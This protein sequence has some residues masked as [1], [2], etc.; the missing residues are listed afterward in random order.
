MALA[1]LNISCETIW[2][3][4]TTIPYAPWPNSFVIR[5]LLSIQKSWFITLN[6]VC[7]WCDIL[8]IKSLIQLPNVVSQSSNLLFFLDWRF[9]M[10]WGA[11]VWHDRQEEQ[12]SRSRRNT[13]MNYINLVTLIKR[14]RCGGAEKR[15]LYVSYCDNSRYRRYRGADGEG[16]G[17]NL[18]EY[19]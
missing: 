18:K 14:E 2:R 4:Y 15:S 5:N 13:W 12:K 19:K 11:V 7:R 16:S 3:A 9:S 10:P 8:R 17:G 1:A 6:R